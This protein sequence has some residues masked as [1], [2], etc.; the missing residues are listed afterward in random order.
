VAMG[1]LRNGV[2]YTGANRLPMREM[3]GQAGA[4]TIGVLLAGIG[5][6]L[7]GLKNS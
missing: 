3:E 4:Q 2:Q 6:S 7:T 5:S 1:S